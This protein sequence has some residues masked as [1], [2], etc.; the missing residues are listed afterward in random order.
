M[1]EDVKVQIGQDIPGFIEMMS[2]PNAA[3]NFPNVSAALDKLAD[4]YAEAWRSFASGTPIPG[5][6][7]VI[8]MRGGDKYVQ[9]IQVY[10]D[11]PFTKVISADK[12]GTDEIEDGK[13]PVDLKPGLLKGPKARQGKTGP[14]N[15]VAFRHGVPGTLSSNK[16]MP[17]NVYTMMKK[18]EPSKATGTI[19]DAGGAQRQTY[20]WGD[21]FPV[22]AQGQRSKLEAKYT[23]KSGAYSGMVKM[24][25][26][27]SSAK[28]SGYMTFRMVSVH[29]DPNSWIIPSKPGMP[30]R[31]A[32]I[33]FMRGIAEKTIAT[34]F[35]KDLQ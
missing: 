21:K 32:V 4:L 27:T 33:D 13:G 10:K 14:Y 20:K 8:S 9:S 28:G 18:A 30:I 24:Q 16:P 26:T 1:A 3:D 7:R 31:V 17:M 5:Q 34:A 2:G 35:E 12:K 15:I 29:S 6:P 22:S 23:W 19:T 11:D 25:D